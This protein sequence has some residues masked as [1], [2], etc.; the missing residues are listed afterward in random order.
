MYKKQS[1]IFDAIVR[2]NNAISNG[3]RSSGYLSR[4]GGRQ[5]T[6][7]YCYQSV[8]FVYHTILHNENYLLHTLDIV[9]RIAPHCNEVRYFSL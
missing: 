3:L 6:I 4:Y 5:D 1:L 8:L 2:M 7:E 9:K